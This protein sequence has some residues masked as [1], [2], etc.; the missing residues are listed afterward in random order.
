MTLRNHMDCTLQAPQSM[1]F[2][3][4]EH[5]SQLLFLTP[6]YLPCP[7]IQ[8]ESL[9]SPALA[10]GFFTIALPGK[11][12]MSHTNLIFR[13]AKSTLEGREKC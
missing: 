6:W 3:W 1:E 5:W 11:P 2:S 13:P 12:D 7:G 8:P 10:N 4:P 9:V